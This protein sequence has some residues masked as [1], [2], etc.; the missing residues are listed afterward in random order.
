MQLQ[1]G[2]TMHKVTRPKLTA[3]SLMHEAIHDVGCTQLNA[4][5]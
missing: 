3:R 1:S 4:R 5:R 2:Q